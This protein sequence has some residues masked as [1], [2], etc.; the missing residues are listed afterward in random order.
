M[1]LRRST[2]KGLAN[3]SEASPFGTGGDQYDLAQISDNQ[4]TRDMRDLE[5]RLIQQDVIL[6][7]LKRLLSEQLSRLQVEESV[8][9]GK[10]SALRKNRNA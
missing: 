9:K 6:K 7:R 1:S 3:I 2:T 8:L 5:K 10:L 4:Q